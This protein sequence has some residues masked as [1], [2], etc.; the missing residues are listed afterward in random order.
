MS[1]LNGGHPINIGMLLRRHAH[2]RPHHT[3]IVFQEKR[4]N[5]LELNREVNRLANAILD[6]GIKKG[7]KI[8]IILP[9]CLELLEIYWAAAKIGA[10]VVPL[11]PTFLP[12][13]LK[14]VLEDS[15]S[16][17]IITNSAL[18][19]TVGEVRPELTGITDE[20]FIAIDSSTIPGYTDYRTMKAKATDLEPEDIGINE[21]DPFNII[22]VS[23]TTG[24]PRGIV[25]THYTRLMYGLISS[26]IFRMTPESIILHSGSIVFDVAFVP[27]MSALCLGATLILHPQFNPEAF[28][29]TVDQEKVTHAVLVSPEIADILHSP[30]FAA[31]RLDSLEMICA[32]GTPPLKEHKELIKRLPD[33]FYE[34]YHLPEGFLTVLDKYDSSRKPNSVGVPGS[35]HQVRIVDNSGNDVRLGEVGEIIGRGPTLMPGYYKRTDL[36][37]QTIKNGW[38]YSSDRGYVDEDGFLYLV[39][40]EKGHKRLKRSRGLSGR[41]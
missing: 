25:H 34:L 27:L 3:A 16:K 31:E 15:D 23:R 11:R 17:V 7:D 36:T 18:T 40:R 30:R 1:D 38:L 14:S 39:D 28:I 13:E 9:N 19:K 2:Y 32:I 22:Y 41:Q 33:R 37:E 21:N 8:A 6:V 29:E 10:V 24:S 20:R 12:K 35:L 5:Y 4:L 26:S